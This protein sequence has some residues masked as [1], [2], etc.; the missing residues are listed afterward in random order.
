[1]QF[2]VPVLHA[3][4]PLARHLKRDAL[5]GR[6]ESTTPDLGDFFGRAENLS[7]EYKNFYYDRTIEIAEFIKSINHNN[8]TNNGIN[9]LNCGIGLSIGIDSNG[10]IY[11]CDEFIN[12]MGNILY[13]NLS[14][15]LQKTVDINR[16]TQINNMPYC[17]KCDLKYICLGGCKAKNL[18]KT[19]SYFKPDCSERKKWAKY[20]ALAY[21]I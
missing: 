8:N 5:S 15:S 18:Q 12:K 6:F 10:D 21:Q 17:Q 1:M 7:D 4:A 19:G 2:G 13:L 20:V 9:K 11:P 14:S 16:Q 3:K